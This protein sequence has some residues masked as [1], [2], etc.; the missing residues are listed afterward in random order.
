MQCCINMQHAHRHTELWH[1]KEKG[2]YQS[3]ALLKLAFWCPQGVKARFVPASSCEIDFTFKCGFIDSNR[4]FVNRRLT[5]LCIIGETHHSQSSHSSIHFLYLLNSTQGVWSLSQLSLGKGWGS[6]PVH[7]RATWRQTTIYTPLHRVN[8]RINMTSMFLGSGRKLKYPER[9]HA[10]MGRTCKQKGPS[11]DSNQEP[12]CCEVMV[13]TTT[14]PWIL[15]GL[16][17]APHNI[18]WWLILLDCTSV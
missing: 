3:S 15:C 6:S 9:T 8:C 5:L 14:T 11:Q 1:K 13:I 18:T 4:S 17:T 10:N 7:H 2:T 16:S 12:S